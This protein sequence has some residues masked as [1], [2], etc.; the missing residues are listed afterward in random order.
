MTMPTER[1]DELLEREQA[2]YARWLSFGVHIG[3]VALVVTF[4]VYLARLLPPSVRPEELPRY[5]G[6]P[7]AE[8]VKATG[9]PT[10]WGWLRRLGE[11]DLLNFVGFA[12]LASTTLV[13]YLR[14]LPVLLA[15]RQR[16][17]AAICIAEIVVLAAATSGM[18]FP[19]H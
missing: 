14:I 17:L 10:G 9:A 19:H 5:W 16:V 2:I 6:L 12:I 13:C 1:D 7:I 11:G 4:V 15:T 3:F 8:Y 18:V